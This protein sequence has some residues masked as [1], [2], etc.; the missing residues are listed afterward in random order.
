MYQFK[1]TFQ[2]GKTAETESVPK[3]SVVTSLCAVCESEWKTGRVY[4][5]M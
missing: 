4:K 5:G 2:K 3:Q 1:H